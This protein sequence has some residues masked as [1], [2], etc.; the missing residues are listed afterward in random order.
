MLELPLIFLGG[1]LGS[2]HCVGMCG[3]F[4]ISIGSHANGLR[5]NFTRQLAYSAGR[6]FTYS[7]AGAIVGYGGLHLT[8]DTLPLVNAQATMA[9]VAG[10]LLLFQGLL[11]AGLLPRRAVGPAAGCLGAT[12]V[13]QFLRGPALYHAFFAGLLNGLLPCGLV[14]A[15]LAL[16]TSSANVLAGW[17]V[18]AA[19][20]LGTMPLMVL[21]GCGASVLGLATRAN[22]FRLAGGAVALT[23][24]ISIARGFGFLQIHGWFT[25]PG[26]PLCP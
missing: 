13:G 24:L 5:H 11:A 26:C 18:M 2:S 1:I 20:G 15:F 6:I 12:F 8:R 21:T 7:T 14:Y 25:G 22:L 3:G 19:F 9:I 10:G 16:A 23:G 4:A 17:A